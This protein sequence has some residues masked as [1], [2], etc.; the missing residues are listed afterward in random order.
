MYTCLLFPLCFTLLLL[1]LHLIYGPV[2]NLNAR[3]VGDLE[4]LSRFDFLVVLFQQR[5]VINIKI[6]KRGRQALLWEEFEF[7][8]IPDLQL[9]KSREVLKALGG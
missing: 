6:Q 9:L 8:A 1:L 3:D 4:P 7:R 5:T 2:I